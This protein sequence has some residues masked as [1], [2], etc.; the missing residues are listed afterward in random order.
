VSAIP[1]RSGTA[2]VTPPQDRTERIK[3]E[4]DKIK[5]EGRAKTVHELIGVVQI[6]LATAAAVQTM[7][8]PEGAVSP[9]A[10]DVYTVQM[11]SPAAATVIAE[12]ADNYPVLGA[13]LDK[14]GSATPFAGL[15]GLG[16]AMVAQFAEN[17]NSLPDGLRAMAPNLIDREDF[18]RQVKADAEK[19]QAEKAGTN[20][21]G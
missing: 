13:M 8:A 5:L 1:P 14:I 3:T 4:S 2:T 12:L 9:F 15:V 10:L 20:G 17:H 7:R 6:P 21:Q 16:I 18:A 11:Y 19:L